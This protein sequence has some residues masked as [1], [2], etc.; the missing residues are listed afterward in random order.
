MRGLDR[1]G[2]GLVV[3]RVSA[4]PRIAAGTGEGLR[5]REGLAAGG[6]RGSQRT[7]VP[8][9]PRPPLGRLR[10]YR[11][12]RRSSWWRGCSLTAERTHGVRRQLANGAP[13][14]LLAPVRGIGVLFE[15]R[16]HTHNNR[17]FKM[18][19]EGLQTLRTQAARPTQHRNA[20]EG[21]KAAGLR[22]G[23]GQEAG[24]SRLHTLSAIQIHTVARLRRAVRW[25]AL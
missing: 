9:P 7:M 17:D 16:T 4:A 1:C 18:R 15:Y 5:G 22:A 24:N 12:R 21:G 10:S 23:H 14:R 13:L 3:Q 20:H 19:Q 25:N 2:I 8:R 11:S 6:K